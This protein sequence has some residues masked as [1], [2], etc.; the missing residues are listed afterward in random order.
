[1][2]KINFDA[3]MLLYSGIGTY[4]REI[5]ARLTNDPAFDFTLFGLPEKMDRF[6]CKKFKA[7][8]PIYSIKEQFLFPLILSK[9]PA[10]LTHIPHYNAPLGCGQ[11][12][13]VTIHDVIHLRF[14]PSRAAYLYARVML[15][16]VTRRARVILTDSEYTKKDLLELIRADESKIRVIPLAAGPQ[17]SPS[18]AIRDNTV[19]YVG[20]LK[21][22]KNILT[23]LRAF[24]KANAR[25]KA[26]KLVLAGHNFMPE[27][28]RA[29]Q[30]LSDIVFLDNTNLGE[31]VELYRKARI[32]VFPSLYEGFGLPPLEAMASG[33]PVICSNATSLPEV[34]GDAAMLF[35]PNNQD[36]LADNIL[37][38]YRD[39]GLQKSLAAK[40]LERS[41][42]FSWD[43]C[44][45][46][47]AE[48]YRE[49]HGQ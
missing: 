48:V 33:T 46:K 4:T 26:M 8:F 12:M 21:P 35:D 24:T 20:N 7:D 43:H 27:E 18:D 32:F 19:L 16:A 6:S 14:P 11:K 31:L 23:L 2:I 37:T 1:M 44:A 29:F 45:E 39:E 13:A 47:T 49:V 22:H 15:E 10:D 3:R 9:H 28:T 25:E 17:F 36:E 38:L 34:V 30:G 41:K 40:G 5:L 42:R